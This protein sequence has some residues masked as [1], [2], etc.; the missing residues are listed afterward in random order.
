MALV[1]TFW[2]LT[3]FGSIE[4]VPDAPAFTDRFACEA[5]A[6]IE[7]RETPVVFCWPTNL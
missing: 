7:R 6:R 2:V 3:A 4:R 1:W 5:A